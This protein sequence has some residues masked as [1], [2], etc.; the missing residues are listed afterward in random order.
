MTT[1]EHD[2]AGAR[3]GDFLAADYVLGVLDA[4]GR[5]RAEARLAADPAF[6][7]EV[8]RLEATLAP[9]AAEVPEVAP[10]EQVWW[11][12][13]AKLGSGE[14]PQ[15]AGRLWENL[16]FWRRL[17]FAAG[18][19]AIASL[20]AVAVLAWFVTA[21]PRSQAMPLVASLVESRGPGHL[22]VTVDPSHGMVMVVPAA[23]PPGVPGVPQLW[24]ILPG[25]APRSLGIVGAKEPT[26]LKLPAEL[27]A[28]MR[29]KVM[30]AISMEPPG[31]SPTG[32]PTGP[33]VA[34]GHLALL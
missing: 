27:M 21:A 5:R 17:S 13:A 32:R 12:I 23:M 18:G 11:R 22:M 34:S 4:A 1:G 30:L 25:G 28:K 29:P 14:A 7:A 3:A 15:K 19:L 10:P 24:V 33:L 9:L 2:D 20:A 31:G 16:A 26:M 6:A 8:A